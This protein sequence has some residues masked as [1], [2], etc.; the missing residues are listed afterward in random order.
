VDFPS[1]CLSDAVLSKKNA[2]PPGLLFR[3]C[4][5]KTYSSNSEDNLFTKRRIN[6]QMADFQFS[7]FGEWN[8]LFGY[9]FMVVRRLPV[10]VLSCYICA[11]LGVNDGQQ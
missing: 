8:F 11:F 2:L 7:N 9:L 3:A 5:P 10:D 4:Q 6:S 1:F